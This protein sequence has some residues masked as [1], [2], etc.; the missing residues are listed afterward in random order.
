MALSNGSLTKTSKFAVWNP[1]PVC[2]DCRDVAREKALFAHLYA[3]HPT[4]STASKSLTERKNGGN[5]MTKGMK[6]GVLTYGE[7]VDMQLLHAV[8]ECLQDRQLL[9]EA[10]SDCFYDL[11]SGSGRMVIAAALTKVFQACIGVE[12]LTSLHEIACEVLQGYLTLQADD[13]SYPTVQFY[14][15]DLFDLCSHDWTRGGVLY[16]NSTCFDD[17]MMARLGALAAERL[18][19]GSIVITLSTSFEKHGF[20]VIHEIRHE[21]SW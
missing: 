12:I 20:Q 3:E 5:S 10:N 13:P 2:S 15:N 17:E 8:L 6:P 18:R 7:V 19:A 1:P 14:H 11:G 16:I 9:N 21:M 4:S